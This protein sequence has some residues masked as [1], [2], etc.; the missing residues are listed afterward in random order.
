MKWGRATTKCRC[1]SSA[2][3]RID[4]ILAISTDS[5]VVVDVSLDIGDKESDLLKAMC[6]SLFLCTKIGAF[7]GE[8][9]GRYIGNCHWWWCMNWWMWWFLMA[10]CFKICIF[11]DHNMMEF[12][13]ENLMKKID[14]M[15]LLILNVVH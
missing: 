1:K 10:K 6:F 14:W 11:S 9:I 2:T 3:S 15:N 12:E 7:F 4:V 8:N 5:N 13:F